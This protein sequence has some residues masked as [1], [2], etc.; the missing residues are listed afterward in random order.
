MKYKRNIREA[1]ALTQMK[2]TQERK[3]DYDARS[4]TWNCTLN[5]SDVTRAR[6]FMNEELAYYNAL[7]EHF[8]SIIRSQPENILLLTGEWEKLFGQL[9]YENVNPSKFRFAKPDC[10]LS[11]GLEPF[12]SLLTGKDASGKRTLTETLIVL[13]EAAAKPGMVHP[14]TRRAMALEM[15]AYY[16]EQAKA[17]TQTIRTTVMGE[18]EL[19]YKTSFATL[20]KLDDTRKR[21]LQIPREALKWK[22]DEVNKVMYLFTPYTANPIRVPGLHYLEDKPWN[23]LVLHQEG[24]RIATTNTPWKVELRNVPSGYMLKYVELANPYL[25]GS[26]YRYAKS[27]SGMRA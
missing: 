24:G 12:R 15:L 21:H 9:A 3:R 10:E 13:L 18:V 26:K 6:R 22:W 23:L 20:E 5:P 19:S 8:N 2:N 17:A 14:R 27:V 4:E 7:A 11:E 16:R 1:N 25:S